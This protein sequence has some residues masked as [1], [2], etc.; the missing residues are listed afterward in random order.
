MPHPIEDKY[1]KFLMGK[2]LHDLVKEGRIIF[3]HDKICLK[4]LQQEK[5]CKCEKTEFVEIPKLEGM[6]CP[7]CGKEKITKE[8]AG[9]S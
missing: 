3:K 4:C 5:D 6:V 8:S 2:N 1:A 7:K 9:I